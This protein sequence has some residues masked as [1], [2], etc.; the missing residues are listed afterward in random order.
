M[1]NLGGF[2]DE[3]VCFIVP[4]KEFREQADTGLSFQYRFDLDEDCFALLQHQVS[5][6]IYVYT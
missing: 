2:E 5:I 6:I 3:Q 1:A 4:P